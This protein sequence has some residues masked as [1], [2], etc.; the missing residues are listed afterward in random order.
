[1]AHWI[2][3]DKGFGGVVYKCSNCG[4]LWNEYYQ[5]YPK[6]FCAFCGEDMKDE[7]EYV[8]EKAT[9]SKTIRGCLPNIKPRKETAVSCDF[10]YCFWCTN[11]KCTDENERKQ[12]RYAKCTD[13]LE[14][15]ND[16]LSKV[17]QLIGSWT[18]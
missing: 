1:M 12:C 17:Y 7:A 18:E 10:K 8:E 9:V 3:E 4:E 15:A 14:K 2:I 16:M 11:G 5:S 13:D 6:D